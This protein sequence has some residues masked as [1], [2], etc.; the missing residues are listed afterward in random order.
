V[1]P[2]EPR[3]SS[4]ALPNKNMNMKNE[5]RTELRRFQKK[6]NRARK[7]FQG[8]VARLK[9][10]YKKLDSKFARRIAFLIARLSV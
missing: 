5:W 7:Q 4:A 3:R 9:R 8:E 1:A 6:R 10:A 2:F